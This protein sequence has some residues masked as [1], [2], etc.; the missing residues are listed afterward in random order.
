MSSPPSLPRA[1]SMST[2]RSTTFIRHGSPLS[3]T[4]ISTP[5]AKVVTLGVP[6]LVGIFPP[7]PAPLRVPRIH[8]V[9]AVLAT[10]WKQEARN[11]A[12]GTGS[13]AAGA[14]GNAGQLPQGAGSL[15]NQISTGGVPGVVPGSGGAGGLVGNYAHRDLTPAQRQQIETQRMAQAQVCLFLPRGHL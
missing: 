1:M 11:R 3:Y 5:S 4:R 9:F 14:P 8:T 2:S 6:C 12:P 15:S 10:N 7:F 13:T